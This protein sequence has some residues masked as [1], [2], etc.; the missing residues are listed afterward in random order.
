MAIGDYYLFIDGI[1]G[2]SETEKFKEQMQIQSFSF[3][4]SNAGSSGAGTG[5]GSG[6]VSIQDFSF[7]IENGKAS[8]QLFLACCKGNHIKKAV[9]T[10]R[11]SG[12]AIGGDATPYNFQV[13]TFT[14]VVISSFHT[15]GSALGD[16]IPTE[17]CSFNFTKIE[18]EYLQQKADGTTGRTNNVSYD[19]KL[20]RGD[21]A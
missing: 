11:K 10:M 21:G 4:A 8:P 20:T 3:G 5:A 6:K 15:G 19:V 7:T 17:S 9:F 14:D 13:I 2:E 16:P 1:K 18:Y 12:G